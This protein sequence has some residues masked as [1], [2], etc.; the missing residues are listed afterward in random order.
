MKNITPIRKV[1]MTIGPALI[2]VALL[3]YFVSPYFLIIVALIGLGL[4]KAGYTGVC[5]MENILT[6]K[7]DLD[8]KAAS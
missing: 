3:S 1:Q 5:P 2:I 8:T 4:T 7:K 6:T